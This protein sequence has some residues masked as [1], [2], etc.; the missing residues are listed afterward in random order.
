MLEGNMSKKTL[1]FSDTGRAR[2]EE[3]ASL[4]NLSPKQTIWESLR[5]MLNIR[6]EFP[7]RKLVLCAKN[8]ETGEIMEYDTKTLLF[9][10]TAP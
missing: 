6:K 4:M 10:K 3:L 7:K 2:L 1:V 8:T 9:K 5:L